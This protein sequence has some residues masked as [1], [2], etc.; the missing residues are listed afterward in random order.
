MPGKPDLVDDLMR[1]LEVH[2]MGELFLPSLKIETQPFVQEEAELILRSKHTGT[3]PIIEAK[4]K[5][6]EAILKWIEA[7]KLDVNPPQEPI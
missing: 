3:H 7:V 5:T 6:R 4:D 1:K 2:I